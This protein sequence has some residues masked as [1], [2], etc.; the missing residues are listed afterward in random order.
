MTGTLQKELHR[1]AVLTFEELSFLLPAPEKDEEQGCGRPELVASVAFRGPFSGKVMASTS[2]NLL[3]VLTANML[4]EGEA[5]SAE[6]QEDA[7]GEIANVVC[8]NLLP[9]IVGS[10]EVFQFE[11]PTVSSGAPGLW[12]DADRPAAEV[13]IV[14]D[15][16][17][18]R[19]L[20]CIDGDRA[21]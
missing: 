4:G 5:P 3:P 6:Q 7:L 15:E 10:Q 12:A 20:L 11:A 8:G 9:A 16:G 1:A 17:W 14:F 19:L 21:A 13:H 18:A 2:S